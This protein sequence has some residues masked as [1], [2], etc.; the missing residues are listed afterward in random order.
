MLPFGLRSA[1][2]IFTAVANTMEWCVHKAGV[3]YIYHYL[4]DFTVLGSLDSEECHRHLLCLQ[5]I[6]ADLGVPLAL[7][8]QNSPTT[9]IVFLGI[10][11]DT[12]HQKL[13]LPEDKLCR[14]LETVTEY[15]YRKICIRR[16]NYGIFSR[17]ITT[18]LFCNTIRKTFLQ[19]A[20]SLLC[21]V[22]CHHHHICLNSDFR[23]GML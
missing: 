15:K 1:P 3:K 10:I 20:I 2:K 14:L 7:D 8:K 19:R 16:H 12:T 11:I 18:C 21:S 5:S 23:S 4:Y 13:R 17:D 6:A 9:V 22:R